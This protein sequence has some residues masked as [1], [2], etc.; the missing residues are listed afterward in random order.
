MASEWNLCKANMSFLCA[1]AP[2]R[3]CVESLIP[4]RAVVEPPSLPANGP[5]RSLF[6]NRPFLR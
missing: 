2:L 3:R 6:D 4:F 5:C 1:F